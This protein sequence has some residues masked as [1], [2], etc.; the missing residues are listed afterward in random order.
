MF[1]TLLAV[2]LA[3]APN[4]QMVQAANAMAQYYDQLVPFRESAD[5]ALKKNE[6]STAL[7][8]YSQLKTAAETAEQRMAVFKGTPE[9]TT[10]K[11][12]T[13][14]GTFTPEKLTG[15]FAAMAKLA[16]QKQKLAEA[17]LKSGKLS[18]SQ[19][20]ANKDALKKW[21]DQLAEYKKQGEASIKNKDVIPGVHSLN[22]VVATISAF[23][24]SVDSAKKDKSWSE[25]WKGFEKQL[26][27]M[28]ADT[29]KQLKGAQ[30]AYD[31]AVAAKKS[32]AVAEKT[33]AEVKPLP[34]PLPNTV[35]TRDDAEE[36]SYDEP[37]QQQEEQ[38]KQEQQ[39]EEPAPKLDYYSAATFAAGRCSFGNCAKDG[40]EGP[41][42]RTRCSFG[43]CF[44]DGWTTGHNG[45]GQSTTRCSFGDCLKDGWETSHPDGTQSNTRC[46][47]GN[48]AKDGWE[49][50]YPDGSSSQTR[51]NF[52]DCFKDGWTTQLPNGQQ[53]NCRCSFGDCLGQGAECD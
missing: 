10:V 41:D 49:T 22:Q 44:T 24:N 3:A 9:W 21:M 20:A 35:A 13:K 34:L 33:P 50:T 14:D 11:V 19:K 31:A 36:Q 27:A 7:G 23:Q 52:G 1:A 48:C 16:E 6:F 5:A 28:K 8:T 32:S 43:N 46:S 4:P 42:S 17:G 51:C 40:W 15:K 26:A 2:S 53:V 18:D 37:A 47:F 39:Q 25:P 29:E 30:K 38:P 45:G 12:K